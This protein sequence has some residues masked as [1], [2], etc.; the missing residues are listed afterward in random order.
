MKGAL[1]V[2]DSGIVRPF[3]LDPDHCWFELYITACIFWMYL[4]FEVWIFSLALPFVL[5]E[6]ASQ[7]GH[8]QHT[9][10]I[11]WCYY[12]LQSWTKLES[13]ELKPFALPAYATSFIR[14][15]RTGRLLFAV[16]LFTDGYIGGSKF[17]EFQ[18]FWI[19]PWILAWLLLLWLSTISFFSLYDYCFLTF[20]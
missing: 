16:W 15:S 5:K 12:S 2:S 13:F 19:F 14:K 7:T 17:S 10:C 20:P 11:W 9:W 3:P 6:S 8:I 1:F 4:V 18:L